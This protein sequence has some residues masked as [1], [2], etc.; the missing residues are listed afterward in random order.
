MF[1]IRDK[2]IKWNNENDRGRKFWKKVKIEIY[3]SNV[4]IGMLYNKE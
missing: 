1:K 2:K 4:G 3:K